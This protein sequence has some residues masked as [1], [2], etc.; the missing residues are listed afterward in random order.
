MG[1]PNGAMDWLDKLKDKPCVKR[2]VF[3]LGPILVGFSLFLQVYPEFIP[4]VRGAMPVISLCLFIAG[5]VILGWVNWGRI[6]SWSC[7]RRSLMISAPI[8][9]VIIWLGWPWPKLRINSPEGGTKILLEEGK[10]VCGGS[11][12][13]LDGRISISWSGCN[14]S[15]SGISIEVKDV[16]HANRSWNRYLD[17]GETMEVGIDGHRYRIGLVKFP[18]RNLDTVVVNVTEV[19]E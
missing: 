16:L 4:I 2:T 11:V 9:L 19:L 7:P 17:A 8:L 14:Y 3:V 6:L 13:A 5:I 15:H 10:F 12:Y 18:R 1:K